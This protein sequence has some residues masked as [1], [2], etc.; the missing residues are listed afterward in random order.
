MLWSSE[1]KICAPGLQC[2]QSNMGRA[3]SVGY[4]PKYLG[5]QVDPCPIFN[6]QSMLNPRLWEKPNLDN[7]VQDPSSPHIRL[8]WH[9]FLL[10]FCVWCRYPTALISTSQTNP[11]VPILPANAETHFILDMLYLN[12]RYFLPGATEMFKI[13]YNLAPAPVSKLLAKRDVVSCRTT[14]ETVQACFNLPRCRLEMTKS[15]FVYRETKLWQQLPLTETIVPTLPDC[16]SHVQKWV[17]DRDA[18]ITWMLGHRACWHLK[19]T[20]VP[21]SGTLVLGVSSAFAVSPMVP[22][23]LWKVLV[24]R[25]K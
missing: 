4:K 22:G 3:K 8:L 11:M 18:G 5:M 12:Q 20:D 21:E 15:N 23:D 17:I 6:E 1:S 10:Y 13:N 7:V 2:N 9:Y 14:R 25:W 16:K 24:N 19:D